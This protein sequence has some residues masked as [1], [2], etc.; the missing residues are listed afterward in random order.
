MA[1][2]SEKNNRYRSKETICKDLAYVLSS[3]VSYGTKYAVVHEITWI[4]SEFNGKHQGCKYWSEKAINSGL[5]NK[6]LIHEHIVPRKVMI[7]AL[8]NME[9]P[10]PDKIFNYLKK[11]CIGVVVTKEEDIRLNKA[12]L[13]SKMPNSWNEDD[14]WERYNLVGIKVIYNDN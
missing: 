3:E 6:E 10:T 9:N 5:T 14:P 8:M 7:S 2:I 1:R 13:R 4:W 11:Y 12:G